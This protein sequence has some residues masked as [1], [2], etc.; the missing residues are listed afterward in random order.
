MIKNIK[1]NLIPDV[2]EDY[3]K[4]MKSNR[5]YRNK[6]LNHRQKEEN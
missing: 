3:K 6:R 5:K 1:I 4:K 2:Q